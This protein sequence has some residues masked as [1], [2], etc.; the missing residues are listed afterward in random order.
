LV[1]VVVAQ[2][3]KKIGSINSSNDFEMVRIMRVRFT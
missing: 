2:L 3:A 1:I